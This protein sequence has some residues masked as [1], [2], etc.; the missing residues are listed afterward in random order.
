MHPRHRVP[1]Q[2]GTLLAE[3]EGGRRRPVPAERVGQLGRDRIL[4]QATIVQSSLLKG[5]FLLLVKSVP[6][7]LSHS[8]GSD[9]TLATASRDLHSA[10]SDALDLAVSHLLTSVTTAARY[11]ATYFGARSAQTRFRYPGAVNLASDFEKTTSGN[12]CGHAIEPLD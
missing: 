2:L 6:D 12:F 8:S 4:P 7:D 10:T 9:A 1:A 5:S 11:G 3:G